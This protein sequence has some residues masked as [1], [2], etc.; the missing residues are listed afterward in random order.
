MVGFCCF[1]LLGWQGV[2]TVGQD[3]AVDAGEHLA[4]AQYLY[5][6]G[7]LPS[8]AQNYEY[9]T[10]ILF[11]AAAVGVQ[12]LL[13][14]A[15]SQPVELS[16]NPANRALWLLLIAAGAAAMTAGRPRVRIAGAA[17]LALGAIWGLD[18]AVSLAKSEPWTGGQLIALA[19]GAGL[20]LVAGLIGREIW[21]GQPRRALAVGAFVAA[22]PVV[23]RMSILFHPEMPFAFLCALAVLIFLRAARLGW[24]GRLGWALGAACGAAA[25]TRQPGVVVIACLIAAALVVGGRRTTGFLV[26]TVVVVALVAGPWWLYAYRTWHN[27]LQSNLEPRASLMLK[28]Q[29]LSFFVSFPLRSLVLHPYRP[30]FGNELLPKLHAELWSDWFGA[31]HPFLLNPSRL[32][33][34]TASSQSV[35]GF[36]GDALAIGGLAALAVPAGLRVVRRASRSPADVGLG[37]LAAVAIAAGTAFVV[38]LIRFPQQFGDPIKSSYLLFTAPAWATF[39]VAAWI[40]ARR[41]WRRIGA[42]LIGVAALYAISYSADLGAALV[43]HSPR[44]S[45]AAFKSASGVVDLSTSFQV[46]S[47]LPDVGGAVDFLVGVDNNGN[48]TGTNVVLTVKLPAAMHLTGRPYYVR[49]TGCTTSSTIVC[50]LDFLAGRSS[51]FIRF[52]V[53]DVQGGP[54]ILTASVSSDETDANPADNSSSFVVNLSPPKVAKTIPPGS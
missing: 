34:V 38:M 41:R 31:I 32:D 17:G 25:L 3:G 43:Q 35:L 44:S 1:A 37:L 14:W 6:H 33:R 20:I 50:H 30:D 51:T 4:Y 11:Q 26:R 40:E 53:Q 29:P 27:P 47:P 21:P 22:Y 28:E 24:P 46:T 48:Q 5:A 42:L 2:S 39:S 52:E 7:S 13:R 10:P 15:P 54:Q 9:A 8:K 18:E 23:Y 45:S 36:F 16:P 12:Y 49:G 19:T